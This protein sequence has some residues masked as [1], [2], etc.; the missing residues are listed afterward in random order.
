[1]TS[2]RKR[3]RIASI[4]AFALALQSLLTVEV[5]AAMAVDNGA[6]WIVTIC[7]GDGFKKV[8]LD[9]GNQ[10]VP[11]RHRHEDC[12]VCLLA[13]GTQIALPAE[14]D[15]TPGPSAN[16]AA[17]SIHP[18]PQFASRTILVPHSRAPPRIRRF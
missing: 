18:V 9:A 13:T 10:P 2:F 11:S 3:R 6:I 1:M 17:P 12:P 15:E 5:L 8:A 7:T 14:A 16:T 4:A